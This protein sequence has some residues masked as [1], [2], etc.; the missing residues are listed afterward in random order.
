MVIKFDTR[1][2]RTIATIEVRSGV[3]KIENIYSKEWVGAGVA[4][5]LSNGKKLSRGKSELVP[6]W[7]I[8]PQRLQEFVIG[9]VAELRLGNSELLSVRSQTLTIAIRELNV[10]HWW[11]GPG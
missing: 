6:C 11:R 9:E 5:A 2:G 4:Y 3:A 10:G 1:L 8:K 7:T